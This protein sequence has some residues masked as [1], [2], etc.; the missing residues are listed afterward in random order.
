MA[1]DSPLEARDSISDFARGFDTL[2]F[3]KFDTDST[4]KN[5][6]GFTCVVDGEFDPELSG[7]QLRC[8]FTVSTNTGALSGQSADG[9]IIGLV[10][11]TISAPNSAPS[12]T[13]PDGSRSEIATEADETTIAE[14]SGF[15]ESAA[16]NMEDAEVE[17]AC[18][19]PMLI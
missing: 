5:V 12:Q 11:A 10:N 18:A 8:S 4:Q 13:Q 6:Q 7:G 17:L 14:Q 19:R 3:S 2:D 1:D 15:P 16:Q 9:D